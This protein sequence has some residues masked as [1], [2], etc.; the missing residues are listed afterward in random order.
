MGNDKA[1]SRFFL[2]ALLITSL[3][4]ITLDLRGN[5]PSEGIRKVSAKV[6][7]PFQT[8]FNSI[9]RPISTFTGDVFSLG[10]TRGK[11]SNLQ[12]ENAALKEELSR[13]NAITNEVKDLKSVMDLAGAGR[14]KIVP[15][16]IIAVGSAAS[17]SRTIQLDVGKADGIKKDMSII[18]GGGLVAR[19]LSV[20]ENS[21]IA[22]LM[23]DETFKVGVRLESTGTL[24]VVSGTGGN[25]L[26]LILLDS[27]SD[28]RVGQ[29]IVARG[30]SNSQPFL[31]GV[32]V[33][34]ITEV[35]QTAGALTKS[36]V[37]KPFV[38]LNRISVVAVIVSKSRT[39]PRDAL[40]PAPPK[41]TPIPTV[42][43]FVT[44]TP[45]LDQTPSSSDANQ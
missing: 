30:S 32:P 13:K 29:R 8:L 42:T 33:G 26:E 35:N 25:D 43:V 37:V 21:A 40:L 34:V 3:L 28:L 18:A 5:L 4:L 16:R 12:K 20:S 6:S 31:P 41:P 7:S 14:Y 2:S 38:D 24:G 22:L 9:Y 27:T 15:A 39:N 1:R 10:R 45:V 19:I 17:F 23:D 11:I 36:A 44:P